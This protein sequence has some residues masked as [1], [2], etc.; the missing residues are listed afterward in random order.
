[1]EEYVCWRW[2]STNQPPLPCQDLVLPLLCISFFLASSLWL[3]NSTFRHEGGAHLHSHCLETILLHLYP[4][5][6]SL[7]GHAKF[8][9]EF[10]I[11][12]SEGPLG[13]VP[14]HSTEGERLEVISFPHC[15][16]SLT[17]F[18][19]LIHFV[20][21]QEEWS[22]KAVGRW[23]VGESSANTLSLWKR[24]RPSVKWN[25]LYSAF[26]WCLMEC[27]RKIKEWD[28]PCCPTCYI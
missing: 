19:S 18:C 21:Y 8:N 15:I 27:E 1:M 23:H 12:E 10:S 13:N 28:L 7:C 25:I 14:S 24:L 22:I 20:V 5:S 6:A 4:T 3:A 16:Q 26:V 17:S 2:R 9:V 11:Q